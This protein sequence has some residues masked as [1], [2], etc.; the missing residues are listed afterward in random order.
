MGNSKSIPYRSNA[1]DRRS[2]LEGEQLA[3][4]TDPLSTTK[5]AFST[6]NYGKFFNPAAAERSP[7]PMAIGCEGSPPEETLPSTTDLDSRYELR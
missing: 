2:L 1:N 6:V 4:P 3:A 5:I 7:P